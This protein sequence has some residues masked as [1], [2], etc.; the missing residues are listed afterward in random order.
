MQIMVHA[1]LKQAVEA[2]R[3]EIA[4]LEP[5][6]APQRQRLEALLTDLE[7]RMQGETEHHA[8]LLSG[9]GGLVAHFETEHPRLTEILNR[10]S[11]LLS[12]M[13]V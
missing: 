7:N 5:E 9:L 3:D 1:H 12:N 13:G 4:R 6:Q 10:I 11:V 8:S 2:L